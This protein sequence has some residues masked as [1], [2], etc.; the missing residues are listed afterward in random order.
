M[1]LS[2][3]IFTTS[4]SWICPAGITSIIV[5]GQG[6]GGGGGAGGLFPTSSIGGGGGMATFLV[7]R[8]IEVVPGTTYTITIG[9]GGTGASRSTPSV[10]GQVGGNT[11]FGSLATFYGARY[12][13]NGNLY[14]ASFFSGGNKSGGYTVSG[15][16]TTSIN[17]STMSNF[18]MS[19]PGGIAQQPPAIVRNYGTFDSSPAAAGIN[20]TSSPNGGAGNAGNSSDAGI[21]GSGGNGAWAGVRVADGGTNASST[22]YGAGGGGGGGGNSSVATPGSGGTGAGGRLIV[23]WAE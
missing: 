1:R 19:T 17:S 11:S 22:S 16:T 9:A 18:P 7:P 13:V 10:P 12:G 20:P 8:I 15:S 2:R 3:Q 5:L 14:S 21:G 23:I 4:G 6:G